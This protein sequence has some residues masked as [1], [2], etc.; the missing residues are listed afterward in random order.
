MGTSLHM[1]GKVTYQ[2]LIA[3]KANHSVVSSMV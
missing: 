3:V 1:S 2:D